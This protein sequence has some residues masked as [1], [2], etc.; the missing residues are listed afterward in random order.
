MQC[1]IRRLVVWGSQ[2]FSQLQQGR[3][4]RGEKLLNNTYLSP[5]KTLVIL[6]LKKKRKSKIK[7]HWQRLILLAAHFPQS[8]WTHV[9]W[10]LAK[11]VQK[12]IPLFK[13][14]FFAGKKGN[15]TSRRAQVRIRNALTWNVVEVR[16]L[17]GRGI[18]K[19]PQASRK[20][21]GSK[22]RRGKKF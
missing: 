10:I 12:W 14:V 18:R 13:A 3:L 17:I 1:W 6:R 20:S 22:K 16:V 11:A 8:Q 7:T 4:E 2:R 9:P 5:T 19:G 15:F 21:S